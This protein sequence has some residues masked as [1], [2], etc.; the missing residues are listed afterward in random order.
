MKPKADDPWL[1][2]YAAAVGALAF[3]FNMPTLAYDV[4]RADGL[5]VAMLTK[6][7]ANG[8]GMDR[9]LDQEKKRKRRGTR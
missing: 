4:L 3:T 2:G 7:G 5:T 1:C 9:L 6:G 8:L